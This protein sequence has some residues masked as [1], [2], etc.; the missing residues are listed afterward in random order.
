[1]RRILLNYLL[2]LI[3][4]FVVYG[5][6]LLFIRWRARI[7]GAAGMPDWRD[8]PWTWLLIA[9][10]AFVAVGFLGLAFVGDTPPGAKY[11]PPHVVEGEIVPGRIE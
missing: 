5:V 8:A 11:I 1:M 7:A 2:P 6:W 4:P 10:V 9:G 3:L